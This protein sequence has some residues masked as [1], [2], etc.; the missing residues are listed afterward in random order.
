MKLYCCI[1]MHLPVDKIPEDNGGNIEA[2]TIINGQ[3]VCVN[4]TGHVQGGK[5]TDA[6]I[7]A[8]GLR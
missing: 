2:S 4:H 1:C 7:M 6:L 8:K 5:F 3:A